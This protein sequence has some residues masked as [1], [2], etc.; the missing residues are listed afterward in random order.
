MI[1][2]PQLP[3]TA[4]PARARH[5]HR[6]PGRRRL[7]RWLASLAAFPAIAGLLAAQ[8]LDTGLNAGANAEI[9]AVAVQSDGKIVVGGN[10]TTFGGQPRARLARF[11]A[12]G[13]LDAAFN[14][15]A[16]GP[17][18]ALLVQ[19]GN[20]LVVG[21]NFT[22]I[23]SGATPRSRL[24]RLNSDGSVDTA[25]FQG[26]NQRVA[27]LAQQ[28]DGRVLVAGSFTQL[29][30]AT[31]TGLGRLNPDGSLDAEFNPVV[32]GSLNGTPPSV[33]AVLWLAD[34][35]ILIGGNFSSVHNQSSAG[36]AR[37][38]YD[39]TRDGVFTPGANGVVH[40]L[41]AATDGRFYLGGEF[42][43]LGAETRPYLA[44]FLANGALD[45]TVPPPPNGAVRRLA[46]QSDGRLLV[47]GI[48][49]EVGPVRRFRLA[50]LLAD[51][52]LDA[53]FVPDISGS[54][55]SLPPGVYGLA[56][57]GTDQIILGG[58]FS[59]VAGAERNGLARLGS[60]LPAILTAPRSLFADPGANVTLS[61]GATGEALA[62]QWR[63][64]GVDLTGATTP[65]LTLAALQ[66]A[67]A[68]IYTVAVSNP[69]GTLL[70]DP[71]TVTLGA[72][73]VTNYA[74]T[75]HA[76]TAGLTGRVQ[77]TGP[78]ARFNRPLGLAA[79]AGGVLFVTDTP[80]NIIREVSTLGFAGTL[81]G[82]AG[83]GIALG[84]TGELYVVDADV[85]VARITRSGA[86]ST[87]AGGTTAGATDGP[88][89]QARF[90]G[91]RGIAV[92]AAGT[93]YVADSDN[94][95]IRRITPDGVVS[96]LAGTAGARGQ[97]D[98]TGP[99]ARFT[100]PWGLAV[101]RAGN[102]FVADR[103][104]VRRLTPEGV[105]TTLA[106]A[107]TFSEAI[108][109]AVDGAGAVFVADANQHT[110]TRLGPEGGVAVVIGRT[111]AGGNAD[112]PGAA[113]RLLSPWALAF[114]GAGNL[115]IADN[116]NSTIRKAAPDTLPL[117]ITLPPAGQSPAAGAPFLL[118][119]AASGTAVTYQWLKDGV[120]LPGAT[121]AVYR[122]AQAAA[123]D[124][125]YYTAVVRSG[126]SAIASAPALVAVETPGGTARL[127]NVATRGL[128]EPGGAL[129]PG[130]VV[131]GSGAKNLVVRGVG[132]TLRNFG[133]GG[134]LPDPQLALA[135]PGG[136]VLLANDD[137]ES[138]GAALVGATAA[139]GAFALGAG[140]KDAAA[141][142]TIDL[143]DGRAYTVRITGR[144]TAETGLALAEVYDADPL[145]APA[146]LANVS[147][148][149][150]V[151]VGTQA[152]VPGFV[153]GGSGTLQLLIRAVGPGLEPFGVGA[154]LADPR[155]VVL[156]QGSE[157]PVAANDDWGGTPALRAAFAA[158][159]AFALPD[160]SKDAAVLVR[161]PAGAYT[162][163][164]TGAAGTTGTA[165]VEIYDVR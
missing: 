122:V 132:P 49:T 143:A 9:L 111:F 134:G 24:A 154:R 28:S 139:V 14:P 137:W 58:S 114:D 55:G 159:G 33:E 147:T 32:A 42:S 88:A 128:V 113:A 35:R 125:G 90:R 12:D 68:G 52:S 146:Q 43:R 97:A 75:T 115:Y 133:V 25:F 155:L 34:R 38:N 140:A 59:S 119:V 57:S 142:A 127:I 85:R 131:R 158:A 10:F 15:G 63:R 106:P 121:G 19:S 8:A 108:G 161:L 44:R 150:F 123:A 27:A 67:Q 162:V 102:L 93:V 22:T 11:N 73:P 56:V 107:G 105:V 51:S 135:P 69:L 103:T 118:Q 82:I 50:R 120:P 96:T 126:G 109:I 61:V 74:V 95:T 91:P 64:N 87:Y 6:P 81:A 37:L 151:G 2:R 99:A 21:G 94:Y 1:L 138:G 5:A 29:A 86:V 4:G 71:A 46:F 116:G 164:V 17:V 40:A 89:L 54:L 60:P 47:G 62:F 30:G 152:L 45:P 104:N 92:D 136:A 165:L 79:T 76:G 13:T 77:A 144:D 65:T 36:A 117:A 129:T 101:D 39:G 130:F 3:R 26:A 78:D 7:S 98:G 66:A 83:W 23:G 112:G 160:G 145:T 124:T 41:A 53:T 100:F 84:P 153:I 31:R 18:T 80:N 163:T 110:I 72:P 157:I 48:F 149:G 20:R 141:L 16:N 70:S 148:R 156:P